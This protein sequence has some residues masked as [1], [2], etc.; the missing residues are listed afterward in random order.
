MIWFI[1]LLA[2]ILRL[3][4]LNQSLWLDEAINVVSAKHFGFWDFVTKYSLG[5]FHPPGYFALLWIWTRLGGYGEIWVRLPSV[6]FGIATVWITYL[7]GRE[8]FNKKAALLAALFM[9]IAPLHVYYSGEARMYS[10]ATFAATLSFYFFWKVIKKGN[11]VDLVGLGVSNTLVL[12]SDYLVYLIFPAQFLYLIIWNRKVLKRFLIP[13]TIN[14]FALIPWILIF[15]KQLSTGTV[16]AS[17]LPGWASVVGGAGFKEL[18]LI[19]LKTF[20]GRISFENKAFY[21]LLAAAVAGIYGWILFD[22]KKID[23]A[24]RILICWILVPVTLAFLISFFIPILSYFR[25]IFILPPLYLLLAK[26][27]DNLSVHKVFWKL[28]V[29]IICSIS[30]LSLSI[31]YLNPKF[32]RED[33]RGAVL[34]IDQMAQENGTILFESNNLPLPFIYYSQNLSPALGGL[35]KIPAKNSEDVN[36][37]SQVIKTGK[38]IYLFEYLVDITDPQRLLQKKIEENYQKVETL[39]FNGVGF[40]SL[41]GLR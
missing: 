24:V 40:V 8:M 35:T 39:N 10:L 18:A 34:S 41:Y 6:I 28:A 21:G 20:F 14:L 31:Y 13:W 32:Q 27:I 7:I 4:N 37:L 33:W 15:P 11:R 38:D 29:L 36:N 16:A 30:L 12:Y 1:L 22:I 19:P 26:G 5:D 2:T 9:A 25:M 3:I 23:G 17:T